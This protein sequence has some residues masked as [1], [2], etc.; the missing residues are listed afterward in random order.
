MSIDQVL[1]LRVFL[2]GVHLD[3]SL[4]HTGGEG[5]AGVVVFTLKLSHGGTDG[6]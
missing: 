5:A 6:G 3:T 1:V 2:H 4:R